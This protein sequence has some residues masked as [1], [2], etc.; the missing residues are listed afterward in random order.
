MTR[1]NAR[2][3][4]REATYR[5]GYEDGKRAALSTAEPVRCRDCDG[6]NCDDGCAYPGASPAPSLSDAELQVCRE[7]RYAFA[8]P[9]DELA[10]DARELLTELD[11]FN[12]MEY[13]SDSEV[14]CQRAHSIISALLERFETPAPSVAVKAQQ[15]A[16]IRHDGKR[17]PVHAETIVEVRMASGFEYEADLA[18]NWLEREGSKSNWHHDLGCPHPCDIVAYRI[19]S[20]TSALSAQVQDV[21]GWQPI[22]TAQK[23]GWGAPILTCRMGAFADWFGNE[24]VGGYAEP[25]ETAYWNDVGVCWTRC[26]APHDAWE[27]THWQPL[28]AAPAKQECGE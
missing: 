26:H 13:D 16:W 15:P 23:H 21:A 11:G 9:N 12:G 28:P 25:P 7:R 19:V 6:Y 27:P 14:A 5:R 1:I 2:Q 3:R 4:R 10:K 22:E 18:G 20:R 24:A 17:M 8:L